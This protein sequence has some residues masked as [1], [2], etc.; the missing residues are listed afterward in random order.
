M[1]DIRARNQDFSYSP[2]PI[3]ERIEGHSAISRSSVPATLAQ[4]LRLTEV[5]QKL[6]E[7]LRKVVGSFEHGRVNLTVSNSDN[8]IM[9]FSVFK[10]KNSDDEERWEII[11][12]TKIKGLEPKLGKSEARVFV[13]N[14]ETGYIE[15]MKI[16]QADGSFGVIRDDSK[17]FQGD[18]GKRVEDRK[19]IYSALTRD[20]QNAQPF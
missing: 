17:L 5:A 6:L 4:N 12:G 13:V 16:L 8:K 10:R 14:P 2:S 7:E 1:G 18:M 11:T 20:L 19:R 9:T 15:R 3:G